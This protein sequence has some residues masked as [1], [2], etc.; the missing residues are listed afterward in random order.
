MRKNR[1]SRKKQPS[2]V[3][4]IALSLGKT[5][6]ACL[7]A[8]AELTDEMFMMHPAYRAFHRGMHG[9]NALPVALRR[10]QEKEFIVEKKSVPGMFMLTPKGR[11]FIERLMKRLHVTVDSEGAL[12]QQEWDGKWRALVFDIPEKRKRERKLLRYEL[13]MTGF[14]RLQKSVWISPYHVDETFA[15]RINTIGRLGGNVEFLV[16]ESISNKQKYIKMFGLPDEKK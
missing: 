5:F 7:N 15:D 14:R 6:L 4:T 11:S 13:Y 16:V 8:A 3:A 1:R 10:L 12:V 2:P 9:R